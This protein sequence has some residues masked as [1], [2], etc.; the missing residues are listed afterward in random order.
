[1][2]DETTPVV[3]YVLTY[4]NSHGMRTLMQP[5]QGRNTF[6]TAAE[7]QARLDAIMGSGVNS[8]ETLRSIWGENP[9]CEVRACDCWPGH[10]DP[11]GV[12]FD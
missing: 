5:A 8:A 6:A 1:M 7:A 11:M 3:R 4:I 12:Y 10:F 2:S 9:Q